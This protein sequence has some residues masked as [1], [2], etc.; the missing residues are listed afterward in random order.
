MSK[1]QAPRR[2]R[3]IRPIMDDYRQRCAIVYMCFDPSGHDVY[4]LGYVS[5]CMVSIESCTG[6][7]EDVVNS[8]RN[9]LDN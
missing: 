2:C 8:G 1:S 7:V 3:K 9:M 4:G 6:L 5:E